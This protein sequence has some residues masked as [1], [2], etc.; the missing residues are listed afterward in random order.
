MGRKGRLITL[1]IIAALCIILTGCP[2]LLGLDSN[3]D[4]DTEVDVPSENG[5]DDGSTIGTVTNISATSGDGQVVL[6]WANPTSTNFD[7]VEIAISPAPSSGSAT[8]SLAGDTSITIQHLEN[9]TAYTFTFVAV[10]SS[11]NRSTERTYMAT[12]LANAAPSYFNSLGRGYDVTGEYAKPAEI[13]SSRI[14]DI[15]ALYAADRS[16]LSL[17]AI[18][19]GETEV[20]SGSSVQTYLETFASRT[21][22]SG[23]VGVFTGSLEVGFS[24]SDY[25]RYGQ[26]F[27]TIQSIVQNNRLS[28]D[29]SYSAEDLKTYLDG[30]FRQRINDTSEEPADLF[31]DY[32]THCIRSMFTG[33]R[34]EY[35][36]TANQREISSTRSFDVLA[37]A[38][39]KSLFGSADLNQS[40][41]STTEATEYEEHA[42][43][44]VMVYPSGEQAVSIADDADFTT[45]QQGVREAQDYLLCDFEDD[46]LIPIWAFCDDSENRSRIAGAFDDWVAAAYAGLNIPNTTEGALYARFTELGTWPSVG[47]DDEMDIDGDDIVDVYFTIN[48]SATND[49]RVKVDYFFSVAE[50]P[51]SG[52]TKFE[53][54]NTRY[55]E[56]TDPGVVVDIAG[57]T[58]YSM[59][60][61]ARG[62][63]RSGSFT[64]EDCEII[65]PFTYTLPFSTVPHINY[66]VIWVADGDGDDHERVGVT[67]ALSVPI[68]VQGE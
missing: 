3:D 46:S 20:I 55:Y 5:N 19:S 17:N 7:R 4:N 45:W 68:V 8:L 64:T 28:I 9:G 41:S 57:P 52:S 1:P 33:G 58:E 25:S 59:H 16:T 42:K 43:V 2:E 44:N 67:G 6:E 12:P 40:F 50:D 63:D 35:S 38:G 10:D 18:D 56:H 39:M 36:A 23:K 14:L 11:G 30:R 49:D 15:D 21:N 32:G 60:A 66:D 53:G 31:R 65:A 34:L 48:L 62:D 47:D 54:T 37:K 24:S 29:S 51:D 27:A 22:L 61:Q 26:Q 13:K